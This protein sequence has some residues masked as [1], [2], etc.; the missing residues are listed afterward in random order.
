M[1]VRLGEREGENRPPW[2]EVRTPGRKAPWEREC[3]GL[4]LGLNAREKVCQEWRVHGVN[5]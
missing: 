2:A 5:A 3:R 4:E 1:R